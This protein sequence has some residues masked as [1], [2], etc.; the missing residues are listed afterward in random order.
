MPF[1]IPMNR[2]MMIENANDVND[3]ATNDCTTL[4][5]D[6]SNTPTIPSSDAIAM[7]ISTRSCLLIVMT[8]R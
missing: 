3:S 4:S 8:F 1:S 5:G 6:D 7:V 2:T